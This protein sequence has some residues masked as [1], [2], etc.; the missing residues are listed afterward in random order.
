MLYMVEHLNNTKLLQ[1]GNC[2]S[3]CSSPGGPLFLETVTCIFSFLSTVICPRPQFRFL[4]FQLSM[5]NHG[6]KILN[7][8][9]Q[10]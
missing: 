9:F 10:K 1:S 6:L 4:Q 7:G 8:K 3:D 5:V 2:P